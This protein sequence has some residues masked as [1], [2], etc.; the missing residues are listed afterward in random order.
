MKASKWMGKKRGISTN[1]TRD[2]ISSLLC[3]DNKIKNLS[4]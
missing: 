3:S 2:H 4:Y 1:I